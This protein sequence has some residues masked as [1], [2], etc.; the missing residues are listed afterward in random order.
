[1]KAQYFVFPS[2]AV[3]SSRRSPLAI[4]GGT[5][6]PCVSASLEKSP[7]SLVIRF[8]C[9][10][11]EFINMRD[12]FFQFQTVKETVYCNGSRGWTELLT[13]MGGG[14]WERCK[15]NAAPHVSVVVD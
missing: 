13:G 8:G 11:W 3:C 10:V 2:L 14:W 15:W 9:A 5:Y 4:Y 1:M 12:F 6:A 7:L